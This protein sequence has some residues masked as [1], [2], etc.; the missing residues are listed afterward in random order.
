MTLTDQTDTDLRSLLNDVLG[1]GPARTA[2][3]TADSGLF[4]ALPEL[5]SMAVANLLTEIEDRFGVVIEDDEVDGDMLGTF[6]DLLAFISAKRV[7]A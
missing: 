4:G 3:L 6:G 1:L 7:G 2:A 5:D